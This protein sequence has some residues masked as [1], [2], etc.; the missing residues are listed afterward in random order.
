M[1]PPHDT[2]TWPKSRV[3]AARLREELEALGIPES[4]LRNVVPTADINGREQVRLGTASV[5]SA[6][7][8]AAALYELRTAKARA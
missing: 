6:D 4:E 8:L 7:R 2:S 3:V 1:H 5:D